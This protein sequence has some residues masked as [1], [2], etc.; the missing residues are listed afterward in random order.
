MY[1]MTTMFVV[2]NHLYRAREKFLSSS[3]SE[4]HRFVFN[5]KLYMQAIAKTSYNLEVIGGL[6]IS[7]VNIIYVIPWILAK[8]LNQGK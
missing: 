4:A 1:I 6:A 8:Y 5:Y 2:C 3:M 7:P